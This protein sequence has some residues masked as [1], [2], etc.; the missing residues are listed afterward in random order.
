MDRR[1]HVWHAP[2]SAYSTMSSSSQWAPA[3]LTWYSIVLNYI[4]VGIIIVLAFLSW[5]SQ[6][7]HY[8]L[9]DI[10]GTL[11]HLYKF[12]YAI[13]WWIASDTYLYYINI[14][15]CISSYHIQ[16]IDVRSYNKD[17]YCFTSH[18]Q[19]TLLVGV[20]PVLPTPHQITYLSEGTMTDWGS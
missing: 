20:H 17:S 9:L 12:V 6:S 3:E 8:I 4:K 15:L 16:V 2:T 18:S 14:D 13:N 19:A 1:V 10:W 5:T 11:W 7:L